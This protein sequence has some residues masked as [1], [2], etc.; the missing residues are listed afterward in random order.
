MSLWEGR[1]QHAHKHHSQTSNKQHKLQTQRDLTTLAQAALP[2]LVISV[3]DGISTGLFPPKGYRDPAYG[4]T[5]E[6]ECKHG[7][8]LTKEQCALM[9]QKQ[10]STAT[11]QSI[12]RC[13]QQYNDRDLLFI[14]V[15][16]WVALFSPR[17]KRNQCMSLIRPRESVEDY[18][19]EFTKLFSHW[20]DFEK[21]MLLAYMSVTIE[22]KLMF[23]VHMVRLAIATTTTNTLAPPLGANLLCYLCHVVSGY[24]SKL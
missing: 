18:F 3:L 9:V 16:P 5:D 1:A 11:I 10:Y 2:P 14:F 21:H 24:D 12:L 22:M 17:S 8:I 4:E 13:I 7:G 20:R 15:N 6:M 23:S 19:M